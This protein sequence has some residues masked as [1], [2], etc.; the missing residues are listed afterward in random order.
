MKTAKIDFGVESAETIFN[1]IIHGETTQTALY[2]FMNRVGTNK[3]NTTK[4]LEMLREHKLQLKRNARASRTIR[5]AL[6]PYSAEL[7]KGRD[8]LDIIQPVLTA[9]RLFYAKQGVGLMNDQILILKMVE[10]ASEL[11]K[12]TGEKVPDMVTAD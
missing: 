1:A 3:R 12:L 11:K 6:R 5:T 10:S 4:A 9:W 2:G 7:A 8:V